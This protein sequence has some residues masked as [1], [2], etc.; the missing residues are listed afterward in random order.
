MNK[1]QN[2]FATPPRS[3]LR[4]R[5]PKIHHSAMKY[6]RKMKNS[7]IASKNEPLVSN[8]RVLLIFRGGVRRRMGA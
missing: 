1:N 6:A 7:N 2:V 8:T 4:N 5:S 3:T